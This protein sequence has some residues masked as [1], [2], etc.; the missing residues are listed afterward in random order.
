MREQRLDAGRPVGGWTG[1]IGKKRAVRDRGAQVGEEGLRV[2]LL[3]VEVAVE[4]R[5]VLGRLDDRLDESGC[6]LEP[7]LAQVVVAGEQL[8][9]L[10]EL[11]ALDD[12]PVNG[13]AAP[14]MR[15]QVSTASRSRRG[16]GRGG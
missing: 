8:D 2:E 9:D 12:R 11:L 15:R 14:K 7:V 16:A 4:Q 1:T 3:T 5:R 13:T 6:A 10:G